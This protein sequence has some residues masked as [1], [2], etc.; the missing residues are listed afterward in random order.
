VEFEGGGF[1]VVE[2]DFNLIVMSS[3]VALLTMGNKLGE[4]PACFLEQHYVDMRR[5]ALVKRKFER[6]H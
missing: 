3:E 6:A 4:P 5:V 1:L 2:L